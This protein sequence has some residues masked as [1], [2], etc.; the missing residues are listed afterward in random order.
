MR[1][2]VDASVAA[3]WFVDEDLRTDAMRILDLDELEAPDIIVSEIANFAWV[4]YRK[5]ELE[6]HQAMEVVEI[7]SDLSLILHSSVELI[8][9]AFR[10]ALML[11]HAIYDCLYIA[12]AERAAGTLVTADARLCRAVRNT[13]FAEVVT[14]LRDFDSG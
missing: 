6:Q 3:K 12:C 2:I 8:D 13:P 9:D 4:K 14:H 7:I 1:L 5:K 11:D 10:I